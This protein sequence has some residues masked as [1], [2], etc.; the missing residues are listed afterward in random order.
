MGNYKGKE[1]KGMHL[2]CYLDKLIIYRS[3]YLFAC[4]QIL[5]AAANIYLHAN[6]RNAGLP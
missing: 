3:G 4:K 1:K 5:F 2:I 6:K